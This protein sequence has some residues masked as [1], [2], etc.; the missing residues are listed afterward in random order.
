MKLL[1]SIWPAWSLPTLVGTNTMPYGFTSPL[2]G[3]VETTLLTVLNG[4]RNAAVLAAVVEALAVGTGVEADVEL[5]LLLE[6]PQPAIASA[7]PTRAI[8]DSLGTGISPVIG[9]RGIERAFKK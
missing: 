8:I 7:T 4:V 5:A 2:V 1:I 3:T 6:L 9:Y